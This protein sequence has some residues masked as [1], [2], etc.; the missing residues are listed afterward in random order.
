M[1]T[2]LVGKEKMLYLCARN[3]SREQ[4]MQWVVP[5]PRQHSITRKCKPLSCI[6]GGYKERGCVKMMHPLRL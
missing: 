6:W 2:I 3:V 1:F 5:S 4:T